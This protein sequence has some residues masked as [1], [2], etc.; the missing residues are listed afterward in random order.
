MTDANDA[1]RIRVRDPGGPYAPG[2]T[3]AI[4]TP[5]TAATGIAVER[6]VGGVEPTGLIEEM[7]TRGRYDWDLALV[8]AAAARQLV[9]GPS[10]FLEPIALD[11][12][13]TRAIPAAFRTEYFVGNDVYATV[14][15]YDED[16]FAGRP[17][18]SCWADF[19]DVT[20]FPGRRAL[21][22]HPID[23]LEE[24]LLADGVAPERLY[25]LDLDRAFRSLDRI[26]PHLVEWWPLA[27][28]AVELMT[29][30]RVDLLAIT[31][32]RVHAANE[33]GARFRVAW[34]QNLQSCDGW[35][36]LRGTPRAELCR[37]FVRFAAT[38]ERQAA[39]TPLIHAAPTHAGAAA[40]IDPAV[41][42]LLPD[43]PA[44]RA[45]AIVTDPAYWSHEKESVLRRF[46]AWRAA[47]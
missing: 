36:I 8:S 24:A 37:E 35:V 33:S 47:G 31:S 34:R 45:E 11:A 42:R 27:A 15:A 43:H 21:R 4:Y 2:L 7:V 13:T 17:A 23:T 40:H 39:F 28:R 46:T 30:R 26:R 41:A 25:P 29:T 14:L 38:A 5:F 9:A 22:D 6:I 32:L 20:R 12:A 10:P 16:A 3:A 19:W 44:N 1:R 18:P